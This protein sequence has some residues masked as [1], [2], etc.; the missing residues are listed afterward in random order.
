[1]VLLA[2]QPSGNA[3]GVAQVFSR[4]GGAEFGQQHV[5]ADLHRQRG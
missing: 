3:A 5:G 1:M 2:C 4:K